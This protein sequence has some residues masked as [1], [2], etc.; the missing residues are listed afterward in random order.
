MVILSI[1]YA[2]LA[3]LATTFGLG[4]VT[5]I[6]RLHDW[7]D[8]MKAYFSKSG[9]LKLT[10]NRLRIELA[11]C[12]PTDAPCLD[13][14]KT[15]LQEYMEALEKAVSE[16]LVPQRKGETMSRLVRYLREFPRSHVMHFEWFDSEM[17]NY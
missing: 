7:I 17:R 11:M 14:V 13:K 6:T 4:G 2:N 3:G 8:T 5:V 15:L 12:D 10:V 16:E 9:Q 1:A